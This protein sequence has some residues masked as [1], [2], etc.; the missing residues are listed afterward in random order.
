MVAFAPLLH[1]PAPQEQRIRL[2]LVPWEAY[3]AFS[4]GLGP[5]PIRVTY[6]RGEMEIMTLSFEREHWRSLLGRLVEVLTEE[7][8]IDVVS[9]GS[10]TCRR[11][12]LQRAFEG[13]ESYWIA[14]EAKMRG[15]VDVDFTVDPPPDL[16]MEIDI[17]R[18][19][20]NRLALYAARARGMAMGRERSE[21]LDPDRR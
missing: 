8:N 10:M 3:V 13:D 11:A 15:R 7:M 1:E 5:R 18:S 4:D 12:D 19:S 14:N 6:D 16:A 17:S 9:A 21:G 2:S 20:M